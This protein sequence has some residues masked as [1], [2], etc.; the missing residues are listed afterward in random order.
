MV[1]E[2]V[3]STMSMRVLREQLPGPVWDAITEEVSLYTVQRI[4]ESRSLLISSLAVG[5]VAL[6]CVM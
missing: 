4:H 6:E 2:E 3:W 1:I 5:V